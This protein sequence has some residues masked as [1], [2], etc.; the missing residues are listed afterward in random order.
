MQLNLVCM[1][2][3]VDLASVCVHVCVW[4]GERVHHGPWVCVWEK[5]GLLWTLTVR[6]RE[7]ERVCYGPWACVCVRERRFIMFDGVVLVSLGLNEQ[8]HR[9]SSIK[10]LSLPVHFRTILPPM[11]CRV[12]VLPCITIL[13]VL[14]AP[15]PTFTA[16]IKLVS[17][18]STFSLPFCFHLN[19]SCIKFDDLHVNWLHCVNVSKTITLG[20]F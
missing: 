3:R 20:P 12:L 5:E 11:F 16:N 1:W 2:E 4:E 14:T 15:S 6:E 10:V 17:L 9:G 19:W 13:L 7:R 8:R 18:R